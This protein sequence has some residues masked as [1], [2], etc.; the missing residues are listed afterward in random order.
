[1]EDANSLLKKFQ[2]WSITHTKS[3][4]REANTTAHLLA[5]HKHHVIGLLT[6]LEEAPTF[7]QVRILTL[8]IYLIIYF[9]FLFL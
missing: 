5:R 9:Y 2:S 8:L 1:M 6:W 4:E 3:S 7:F